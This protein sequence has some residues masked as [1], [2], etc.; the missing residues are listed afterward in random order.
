MNQI[1]SVYFM[2]DQLANGKTLRTVKVMDDYKRE[3]LGIEVNTSLPLS[4]VVRA[5]DQIIEWIGKLSAVRFDN[6]PEY[7][8]QTLVNWRN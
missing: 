1:W 2:S 3:G 4:H 6:G 5:L 8:N 7:L